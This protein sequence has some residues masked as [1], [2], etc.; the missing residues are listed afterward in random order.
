MVV[1]EALVH[2]F[3]DTAPMLPRWD[4]EMRKAFGMWAFGIRFVELTKFLVTIE[5]L[6]ETRLA[7]CWDILLCARDL[8]V[9]SN[10]V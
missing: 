10:A 8:R 5:F 1:N 4:S 6:S 3:N 9:D 7:H 2:D